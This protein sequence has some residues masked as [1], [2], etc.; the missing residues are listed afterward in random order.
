MV[1]LFF[2]CRKFYSYVSLNHLK[3][4]PFNLECIINP[5]PVHG[6]VTCM[7]SSEAVFPEDDGLLHLPAGAECHLTCQ[8]GFVSKSFRKSLCINGRI[9]HPL[10]CVRPDAMI[11]I[12][13]RSDT[14]G[15]LNSVE[16]I[17][18]R[19]VC[20]GAVPDLPA[21]RWRMITSSIDQV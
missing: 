21:M 18:G 20:R 8:A 11:L 1:R 9:T 7:D 3:N 13:G 19:G 14:Y 5:S 2:T 16:L 4:Q 15:V 10:E 12:G 6:N 17:T